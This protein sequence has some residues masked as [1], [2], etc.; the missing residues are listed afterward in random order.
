MST[1]KWHQE[2]FIRHQG[3]QTVLEKRLQRC[4]AR[5]RACQ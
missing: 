2:G 1:H 3:F 5:L 4:E